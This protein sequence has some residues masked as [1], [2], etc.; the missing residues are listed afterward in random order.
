MALSVTNLVLNI[1]LIS[2]YM[3]SLRCLHSAPPLSENKNLSK[4]AETWASYL[5]N[6]KKFYHS[7]YFYGE[8]M[9]M[10]WYNSKEG[11]SGTSYVI[12]AINRWYSELPNYDFRYPGFTAGHFSQLVWRSSSEYGVAAVRDN[13]SAVYVVMEYNPAGNDGAYSSNVFPVKL[14]LKKSPRRLYKHL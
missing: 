5:A 1:T 7:D 8:N 4:T 12:D 13:K 14:S 3:N 6:N 2:N 11:N 9:A 10:T